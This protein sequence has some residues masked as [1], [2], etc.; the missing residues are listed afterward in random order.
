MFWKS[1]AITVILILSFCLQTTQCVNDNAAPHV[2]IDNDNFKG[3]IVGRRIQEMDVD[4][5]A[6]RGIPYAQAPVNELRFKDP[7]KLN[8]FEGR[9][10]ATHNGYECC[11]ITARNESEDC[12]NLN[13][14]T[15]QL[16]SSALKPVLVLIHPGGLY[17]GSAA[18]Y[19][20]NPS[21][22]ITQDIV[23]VTFNYRLG[24]LGFLNL[25]TPEIPGNA[26]FKDQVFALHWVQ[27]NIESFGGNPRDVTLM[28][29]SAGALS[30]QLH[31]MSEL[32][33][34]LFHQAI[35][36]S[37]SIAPQLYLPH[38]QQ[39]YLAV[40]QAKRLKCEKFINITEEV[41]YGRYQ[42]FSNYE[43]I[44]N[45]DLIECLNS[46]NGSAIAHSLRQMFDYPKDNPIWL[47]LPVI[48]RDFKQQ[49][50]LTSALKVASKPILL[51]YANGELCT[52]AK[53]I[54]EDDN[55]RKEISEI[56]NTFAP[57]ALL[58]ERHSQRD[59]IS[60]ALRQKY[61]NGSREFLPKDHDALCD[62][63]SDGLLRFGLHKFAEFMTQN[64]ASVYFYEFTFVD[65]YARQ[66]LDAKFPNKRARCEHMDDF[67]YLF[68]WSGRRHNMD[69]ERKI[70]KLYTDFIYDFMKN[71]KLSD[72]K[73]KP[74]PR[75]Y[76][77]INE[78]IE[79]K[80]GRNFNN[81]EFWLQLFPDYFNFNLK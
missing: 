50:F 33:K 69:K 39:K 21:H 70:V 36:M 53:K 75:T 18:S 19:F 63:F 45:E 9:L 40:R 26:G 81:Y 13:V 72:A 44:R 51:G 46:F 48:E 58:Y 20:M 80:E 29:Y 71:G 74:Y 32:S 55:K 35:L 64:K 17:L 28:G 16:S 8:R 61:F 43:H 10:D 41:P 62:L 37:G 52:S 7:V 15:K 23:V 49:R 65:D 68:N 47:W 6:F 31:L 77:L 3:S 5:I 27:Q 57:R 73:A 2:Y 25:G 34:D 11:S 1:A 14:Y 4:Y 79:Y 60:R 67:Q 22:M 76:A 42:Q 66:Q 56:F 12:L 59:L 24:T 30:V 54:L 38:E 78:H